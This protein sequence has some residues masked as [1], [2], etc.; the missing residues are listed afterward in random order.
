MCEQC[1]R[2]KWKK[3][4]QFHVADVARRGTPRKQSSAFGSGPN[5]GAAYSLFQLRPEHPAEYLRD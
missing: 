3:D 5:S 1:C 2:E 4:G